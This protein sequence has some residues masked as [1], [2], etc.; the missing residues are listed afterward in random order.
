MANKNAVVALVLRIDP[1]LDRPTDD[2]G[3][4]IELDGD[5]RARIEPGDTNAGGLARILDGLRQLR[6][7]VYLELDPGTSAITRLLIPHVTRVAGIKPID[8]GVLGVELELSHARHLLRRTSDDVAEIEKALREAIRT[9]T[10][11]VVT[12][13]DAHEIIDVRPYTP[14]PGEELPHFPRPEFPARVPW[15]IDWIRYHWWR[16]WCWRWW[17]WWWFRCLSIKRAQQVFDAMSATSCNPLTVPVPCIPFLYPDDGCWGRAS[18]MCRL[19]INMGLSPRKVWIQGSLHVGTKNNPNC[20]VFW[21]WHV[22]PTLCVRGPKFFQSQQMVID[23]SLFTTPVS[24][25]TW[26]GVQGDPGASLTPSAA[27]IFYLW[28][29][30]TDPGYVQTNQ[31]LATYR[32]QLQNRSLGPSGP[33]PYANCP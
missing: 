33:P 23:P 16:L 32:L 9:R 25:S 3:Y 17:P 31:V 27:S 7:P 5:R 22:A 8:T 11:V 29:N 26:K 18:E 24:Q 2:R 1:P 28:G 10:P 13:T 20:E 30:V 19:M 15:S 14:I 6:R 12:E 21:G 4:T